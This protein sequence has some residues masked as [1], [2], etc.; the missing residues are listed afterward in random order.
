VPAL[1][2]AG[3]GV[4]EFVRTLQVYLGCAPMAIL[5]HPS[6]LHELGVR[7]VVNMCDE[8]PGPI[9]AYRKLGIKQLRLPTADHFEPSLQA[10]EEATRFIEAHRKRGEKVY[11]HC[12]AGHGRGASVAQG[13][14]M[15]RNPSMSAQVMRVGP[16]SR[17]DQWDFLFLMLLCALTYMF[18]M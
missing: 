4:T 7:G 2:Y 12:K 6:Q 15:Y 13:W 18:R 5:G 10:L 9:E 14:L 17:L 16:T 3:V 8:Y 1:C 11:V